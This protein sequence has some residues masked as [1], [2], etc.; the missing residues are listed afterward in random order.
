MRGRKVTLQT[1]GQIGSDEVF[2]LLLTIREV[3]GLAAVK[4]ENGYRIIA[5]EGA[6]QSPLRTIVGREPAPAPPPTRS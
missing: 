5:R 1:I 4:A 2:P 6:Q 3:N